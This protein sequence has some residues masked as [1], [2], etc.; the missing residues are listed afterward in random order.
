MNGTSFGADRERGIIYEL[1]IRPESQ[2]PM[3]HADHYFFAPD[4]LLL[5]VLSDAEGTGS[6]ALNRLAGGGGR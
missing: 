1:R 2:T 6:S 3:C 5:G 4:G